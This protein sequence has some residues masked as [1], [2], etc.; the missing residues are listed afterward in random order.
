MGR[1]EAV[2]VRVNPCRVESE[3]GQVKRERA[4]SCP[5]L[6][7]VPPALPRLNDA[8]PWHTLDGLLARGA[9]GRAAWVQARR[10]VGGRV[11]QT[12]WRR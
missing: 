1:R 8:L 3:S 6:L 12:R 2:S 9:W 11:C 10:G 4:G 7:M 5:G